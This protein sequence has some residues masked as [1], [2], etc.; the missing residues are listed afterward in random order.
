MIGINGEPFGGIKPSS[1]SETGTTPL[2]VESTKT[3][4]IVCF[5]SSLRDGI[6]ATMTP[7]TAAGAAMTVMIATTWGVRPQK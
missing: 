1:R 6:G 3:V 2:K 7:R 4:I 5:L